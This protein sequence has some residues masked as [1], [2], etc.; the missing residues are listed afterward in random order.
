[1]LRLLKYGFIE[2]YAEPRYFNTPETMDETYDAVIIGAGGHGLACAYYLAKDHGVTN[3][4]VLEK[5]YI[6]GGN[7]GRNTTIVRSNYL[8]EEGVKFYD[9]SLS[10]F[11][12][13]SEEL[14]FNI[15]YSERGHYTLAH[16]DATL[17]TARWRAEVNKHYGVKSEV[18]GPEEIARACPEL[19]LSCGGNHEILGAL[20]HAP[21]AVA[22]HDAVAW[23]Y[24]RRASEAGVSIFQGTEVIAIELDS[25]GV[26]T[27]VTNRGRIKTRKV[28]SAVAGHTPSVLAMVGLSSP[29]EIFPL[30]ACVTEPIKP[31]LDTII[32]SGSLHLYVSQSSRGEMVMGAS[33]DPIEVHSQ[34]STFE[35]VSDICDQMLDLFPFL[36]GVKINRQWA[37]MSDMTPDFAP[38]MGTTPIDGF[39]LDAGWGT[40]GFKATPICGRTMAATLVNDRNH[41]L[42]TKFN[43]S[44]FQDYQL[45][46]EKGAAAVG[47]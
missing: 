33:V 17:R 15:F 24:A 21:G 47:H 19:D 3:V 23:G 46:G 32:V 31:W 11:E 18:V 25:S 28:L 8:T 20:Y 39:Y 1:M 44:R 5:G 10:L 34:R 22:R 27:V 35:F 36:A 43:L 40:W 38:I 16:S 2:G 4:A 14:D 42:I 12:S 26:E 30:Q 41:E 9:A 6:G 45:V 29:I 7:T 37:G 13:L